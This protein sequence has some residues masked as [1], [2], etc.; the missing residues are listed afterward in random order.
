MDFIINIFLHFIC[1]KAVLIN[2]I[3]NNIEKYLKMLRTA[4]L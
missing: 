1:N 3:L 2:K 4:L